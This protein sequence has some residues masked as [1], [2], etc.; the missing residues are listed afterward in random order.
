ML[1]CQQTPNHAGLVLLG[2]F[3]ALKSLH[4]FIH[5][6]LRESS[7][8]EDK[9]GFV[10]H[11]ADDIAKALNHQ[12]EDVYFT[13]HDAANSPTRF[14]NERYRSYA[15]AILWPMLLT[16]VGLLRYAMAFM[17]TSKLDQAIMFELEHVVERGLREMIPITADEVL[18]CVRCIGGTAYTHLDY[19]VD[20]RCRYFIGLSASE[21]LRRLP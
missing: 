10:R 18:H 11:L 3:A 4:Q 12:H 9:Q 19:V 13:R 16:Q 15:L 7:H 17:P 5:D 20:S 8:I 6:V 14:N 1:Y 21:R 2:D